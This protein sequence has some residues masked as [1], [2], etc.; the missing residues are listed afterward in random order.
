MR[1][2]Q[3]R[4]A[5]TV[6]VLVGLGATCACGLPAMSVSPTSIE[7]TSTDGFALPAV[8]TVTLDA[9]PEVGLQILATTTHNVVLRLQH[10]ALTSR[11][12]EVRAV[13]MDP[14][15]RGSAAFEDTVTITVCDVGC[16]HQVPNSPATVRVA[17]RL[18]LD[19]P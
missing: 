3:A 4:V 8:F 16:L 18:N 5:W 14:W 7:V 19:P 10:V 15:Q 13:F 9:E 12:A 17:Y 1:A 2:A 11:T 6:L